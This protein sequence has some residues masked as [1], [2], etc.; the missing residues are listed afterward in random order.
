MARHGIWRYFDTLMMNRVRHMSGYFSTCYCHTRAFNRHMSTVSHPSPLRS[1]MSA[2]QLHEYGD[3]NQLKLSSAV[4][5]PVVCRPHDVLVRVYAASVNPVDV[6][7]VGQWISRV[8]SPQ[9]SVVFTSTPRIFFPA[10]FGTNNAIHFDMIEE[11]NVDYS[12]F[13][14]DSWLPAR[15]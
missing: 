12:Y 14:L 6:M 8:F 7:M 10:F 1:K 15:Q 5:L 3:V 4:Q 13:I 11:F 2:W 9:S